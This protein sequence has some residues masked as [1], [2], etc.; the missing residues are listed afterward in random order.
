V[1]TIIHLLLIH[2][3]NPNSTTTTPLPIPLGQ[4]PLRPTRFSS[5]PSHQTPLNPYVCLAPPCLFVITLPRTHADTFA[6]ANLPLFLA[7]PLASSPRTSR[8]LPHPCPATIPTHLS[9]PMPRA[10]LATRAAAPR[11]SFSPPNA[12]FTPHAP[13]I[14]HPSQPHAHLA[15]NDAHR[16]LPHRLPPSPSPSPISAGRAT[17]L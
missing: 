1:L 14:I 15:P 4:P 2:S 10:H 7:P 3:T 11:M 17:E 9:S 6:L 16:L 13:V 5:T 8:T 12:S